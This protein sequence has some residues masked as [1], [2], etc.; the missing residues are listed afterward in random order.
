MI[1]VTVK[2]DYDFPM[3]YFVCPSCNATYYNNGWNLS[4]C[5][6]IPSKE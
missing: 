2:L 6:G 4:E 5:G 1:D 3:T